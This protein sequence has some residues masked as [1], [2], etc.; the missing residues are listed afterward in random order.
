[1]R[2]YHSYHYTLLGVLYHCVL[3]HL[4][5]MFSSIRQF[6]ADTLDQLACLVAA[7]TYTCSL[8]D[9]PSVSLQVYSFDG[10]M[11]LE[12]YTSHTEYFSDLESATEWLMW[13]NQYGRT[14]TDW[15]HGVISGNRFVSF[16]FSG[17]TPKKFCYNSE[18]KWYLTYRFDGTNSWTLV[19]DPQLEYLD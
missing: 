15:S 3:L 17:A 10:P 6:L 12:A 14:P 7:D 9:N 16:N 2:T 11:S 5:H 8:K 13:L 1:M 18:G 4:S 19:P